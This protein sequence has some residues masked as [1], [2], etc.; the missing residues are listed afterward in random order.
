MTQIRRSKREHC[1]QC[2]SVAMLNYVH[3]SP[4]EDAEVFAE[5]S[6]CGAFVARYTLRSYTCDDP[7]RSY[8]RH[9]RTRG[10]DSGALARKSAEQFA[11]KLWDDYAEVKQLVA[12]DEEARHL[13]DLLGET[14]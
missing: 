5:C 4:G 14:P 1:P 9:M 13:E 11:S 7:Y 3:V 12:E 8:L 2:D 6:E 10:H